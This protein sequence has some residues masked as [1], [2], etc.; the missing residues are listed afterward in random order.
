MTPG[1][2]LFYKHHCEPPATKPRERPLG[3]L[4]VPRIG[5]KY[6]NIVTAS[7]VRNFL[8]FNPFSFPVGGEFW[9]RS[10]SSR[11]HCER[12]AVKE[13]MRWRVVAGRW[14][15]VHRHI[16]WSVNYSESHE[17]TIS[18]KLQVPICMWYL[19]EHAGP[20]DLAISFMDRRISP[21]TAMLI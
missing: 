19:W 9:W 13:S 20:L 2:P 7:V 3:L 11:R 16:V 12:A 21:I 4:A 14:R 5:Q 6:C 15:S 18:W 10:V 8:F 17:R 1:S